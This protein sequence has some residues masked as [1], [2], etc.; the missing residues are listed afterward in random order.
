M[1]SSLKKWRFGSESVNQERIHRERVL[2]NKDENTDGHKLQ[3][4]K[5]RKANIGKNTVITGKRY[6]MGI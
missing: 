1:K 6:G 3:Y 5:H 2:G 4:F